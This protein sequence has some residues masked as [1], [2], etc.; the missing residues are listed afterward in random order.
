MMSRIAWP[1]RSCWQRSVD[2]SR[3]VLSKLG[4]SEEGLLREHYVISKRPV[5]EVLYGLLRREWR[6]LR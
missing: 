6:N 5:D 3:R 2:A 4:F 1:V